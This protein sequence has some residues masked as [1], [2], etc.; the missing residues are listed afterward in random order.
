[1]RTKQLFL[2]AV[3][4]IFTAGMFSPVYSLGLTSGKGKMSGTVTDAETGEPI[5]GVTIKLFFPEVKAYHR[6]FPQTDKEG[7]WRIHYIR[8]GRWDL[9]FVKEGYEVKQIS[10]IVDPTPGTKNPPIEIS[11]KKMEGPA[12]GAIVVKEIEKAKTLIMEKQ[13]DQ[14]LAALK[15]LLEK[16]QEDSG[17]D[18]V[19][20]YIGNCYALKSDYN[21][22]IEYYLKSLEKFPKN[23]ELL[24]SIGN[25]YNNINDHENAMKWFS[26]LSIDDIGNIDSLYNIGVIA[27]N[28]GDFEMAATYF[29]KSTEIDA[30]FAEGFYQ[31]GMTYTALNKSAE[32]VEALKKFMEIAP[33]SPNY[34]TAKA[35]VDAFK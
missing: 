22:A 9:D 23:K 20:L 28:K 27:Y 31:L 10:F 11:L 33:D 21:K 16:Y 25:A 32:A 30:T 34:D 35:V 18:I 13:Y 4:I 5:E 1:M 26:K 24:L 19:N 12:V 6:P 14:A 17:I 3:I 7:K 15:D 8:K 2:I 29:K